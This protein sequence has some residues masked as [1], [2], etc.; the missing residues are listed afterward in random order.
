MRPL[1]EVQQ[2][3]K[4]FD[5]ILAVD[6]LSFTVY[7]GDVYG[8]LGQ[9]GAGKSTTMRM[10]L[11]LIL[12]SSGTMQVFGT[13]LLTHRAAILRRVGAVIERPDLYSYLSAYDNLNIFARMT[14]L[15][16]RRSELMEQ[17]DRVGLAA[18]AASKVKTFSQGMKQRLGIAVA[19]VH[20][21]DLVILDEPTNGLDP[22]G[23]AD[24]RNL[25]RSLSRDYG[26][27]VMVS[28]H[29]LSE[30]EQIATR[31]LIIDK[32]RKIVEGN[33]S[34]FFHPNNNK[35]HLRTAE[36]SET[37]QLLQQSEWNIRAQEIDGELVFIL[38]SARIPELTRFLVE[39][40]VPVYSIKPVNS[41][42]SYFLSLTSNPDHVES[43][44][45]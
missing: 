38:P 24:M 3:S 8:F 26:K 43:A 21:P 23:I 1:V 22:Q 44:I 32:G 2:L 17:L 6:N 9:N 30:I 27:T 39:N 16:L 28:S 12:P 34:E 4:K 42:E 35:V 29:L 5:D 11:S 40:R 19:L 33:A 15:R 37:Q 13:A 10:L 36:P 41:L 20:N 25:I 7:P 14:G 45:Y 18:R 31:L